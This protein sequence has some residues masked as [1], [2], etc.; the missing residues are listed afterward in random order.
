MKYLITTIAALVLVGCG[1][2]KQ[3]A[4]A[5]EPKPVEPVAALSEEQVAVNEEFP[6][7]IFPS[8]N[9]AL[10]TENIK[11]EAASL[12]PPT[13]KAPDI[14]IHIAAM[15]GNIEAV[16]QHITIGTDGNVKDN[17]G[18]TSLDWSIQFKK[19]KTTDLLGKHGAKTGE[20]LKAEWK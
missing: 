17:D 13:A 2:S 19:P 18:H 12:E 7:D 15:G 14:P 4:P 16:K 5:P 20:E 11:S 10:D 6:V 3:S 1:E 9:T 8:K